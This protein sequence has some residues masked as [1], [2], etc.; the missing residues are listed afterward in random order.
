[1]TPVLE[2]ERLILRGWKPEDFEAYA[3]FMA[4]ADVV[5]Y[6]TGEPLSRNDAWRNMAMV[7]GH[8]VLRGFGMWAVE[9]KADGTFVGRVGMHY[10]EGW[11]AI[12]VGWT[13]GKDY[14]GQGF[15]TEAA[16]AAM[17]YAFLAHNLQRVISVIQIDNAP[18]QA[19][20]TRLGETRGPRHDI[21]HSGKTFATDIWSISRD[22]WRRRA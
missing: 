10:P 21:V 12:E 4:D 1:M 16:R 8:W 5:R 22:E 19:V 2:T 13:L 6:L 14:W 17:A 20:A 3:R 15:A 11:P 9:R 7:V 18:S